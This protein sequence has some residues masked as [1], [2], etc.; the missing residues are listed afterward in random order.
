M[1]GPALVVARRDDT[2]IVIGQ[3]VDGQEGLAGTASTAVSGVWV[4][5]QRRDQTQRELRAAIDRQVRRATAAGLELRPVTDA[6][7]GE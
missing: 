1:D 7:T 4:L 3:A 6:A 2:R 5:R